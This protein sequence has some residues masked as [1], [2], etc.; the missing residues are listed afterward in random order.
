[1]ARIPYP[2]PAELP[3]ETR[4]VLAK[5]APLNIFRMLAHGHGLLEAFA[6]YGNYILFKMELHPFLREIAILRV[7]HLSGAAYEVHQHERIAR[8]I[9]MSEA[10]V[11]AIRVGPDAPG[12]DT[13]ERVVIRYTDEVVKNVK[14]SDA[15]FAA[16]LDAL[17]TRQL[18]ELTHTIGM[19][20]LVSR[21]LENFEVDIE[22]PGVAGVRFP[23]AG[24][25]GG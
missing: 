15:T 2:D 14:A 18:H 7:G 3:A 21:L 9:G 4:N 25:R 22:E 13:T 6:R 5:M 11:A 19:Y 16:A 24:P 8:D 12:L 17:G 1:M 23:K 10:L 20:M